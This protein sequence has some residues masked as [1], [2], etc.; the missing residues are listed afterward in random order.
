MPI[1]YDGCDAT[2]N[3]DCRAENARLTADGEV[4]TTLVAELAACQR[5]LGHMTVLVLRLVQDPDLLELAKQ[6]PIEYVDGEPT[7]VLAQLEGK[8]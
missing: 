8:R 5:R 1:A 6:T 2:P 4:M 3:A 7:A